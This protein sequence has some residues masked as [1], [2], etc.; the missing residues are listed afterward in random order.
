[1]TR[2]IAVGLIPIWLER[3]HL[4]SGPQRGTGKRGRLHPPNKFLVVLVVDVDS[5]H[6]RVVRGVMCHVNVHVIAHRIDTNS[7]IGIV[8]GERDAEILVLAR[9]TDCSGARGSRSRCY[10]LRG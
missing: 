4:P 1:M 3:L 5:H 7:H 6:V 2:K 8:V 9:P 10:M